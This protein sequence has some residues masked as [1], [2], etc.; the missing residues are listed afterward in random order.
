MAPNP[1][2]AGVNFAYGNLT[3][4]VNAFQAPNPA[5]ATGF[6]NF[7]QALNTFDG[8]GMNFENFTGNVHGY[9]P[10]NLFDGAGIN[11]GNLAANVNGYQ[12]SNPFNGA[13]A[14]F[15]G[16]ATLNPVAGANFGGPTT[17]NPVIGANFGDPASNLGL[18][19]AVN[20]VQ[21]L[22]DPEFLNT[23]ATSTGGYM[24]FPH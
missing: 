7:H 21:N 3:G 20:A 24:S 2:G 4:N 6:P 22:L 13:G 15:R 14:N 5:D 12:P 10:S 8:A 11:F 9:Q 16:P 19:Q 18:F 1:V 17:L 23:Q